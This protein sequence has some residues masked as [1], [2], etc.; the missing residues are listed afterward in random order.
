M[1]PKPAA[2]IASWAYAEHFMPES[3]AA[4]AA[5]AASLEAGLVPISRGAAQTL[6]VLARLARVKAA[7]EVGTGTGVASLALLAGMD[8]SGNLTSI[9]TEGD[10]LATAKA[11]AKLAGIKPQRQRLIVGRPL[12]I[13]GKLTDA[14]YDLVYIDS[15]PLSSGEHV[16]HA[17]RV[18]R[19]TG[20]LI[21]YHALL[22]DT[23]A[24]ENNLDDETLI[25]R[26]TLEAVRD[27]DLTTVLLPI[28]DGLLVS[29]KG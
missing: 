20:L 22:S 14:A 26:E 15:D 25:V 5:R 7:V 10:H 18:L 9:D 27:M 12:E 2:Q 19:P 28:G 8:P 4:R 3:D 17:L 29:V 11:M 6:T 21:F 1:T 24:R 16:E 23:V 13:L